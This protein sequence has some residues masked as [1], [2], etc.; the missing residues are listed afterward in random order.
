MKNTPAD[1]LLVP[2]VDD[3]RASV[4][5]EYA[6]IPIL[7]EDED[8]VAVS[9]PEGLATL[10]EASAKASCLRSCLEISRHERLYVVHRLDKEASGVILFARNAAAHKFLNEQFAE[11]MVRK[12]Y[13]ALVLGE[14]DQDRL[15]IAVPL[16]EFG[17]GRVAV[18]PVRGKECR[19]DLR[20]LERFPGHTLVEV[21]PFTGRRHQ[22]RAHLYHKG[23]PI[24]GDLRYGN[25]SEQR[26][27]GR[28]MLHALSITV[29]TPKHG[30]VTV[31]APVPSSFV[32]IVD[33]LRSSGG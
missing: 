20:M 26:R 1:A 10:P 4:P 33:R 22:I 13:W 5:P 9:K 7:Y 29:S 18:D 14:L 2:L 25:R 28:L 24:A 19:T 11:R 32:A 8:I 27:Y 23:H 3:P 16:R 15:T 30:T 6:N 17:S 21:Q 12:I 31:T